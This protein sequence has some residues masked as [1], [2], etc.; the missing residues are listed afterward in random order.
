MK[1]AIIAT[2]VSFVLTGQ[3]TAVW[4]D[5]PNLMTYQGRLVESNLPVTGTRTVNIAL[6]STLPSGTGF[7]AII[8]LGQI[9]G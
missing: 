1:R 2:L 4:A 5:A 8:R 9:A 7:E 6:C 3:S